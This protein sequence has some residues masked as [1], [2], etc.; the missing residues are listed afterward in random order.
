MIRRYLCWQLGDSVLL[1]S[2]ALETRCSLA[3]RYKHIH[4]YRHVKVLLRVT[5]LSVIL[6]K[7]LG[8][9]KISLFNFI[10]KFVRYVSASLVINITF[11]LCYVERF[12]SRMRNLPFFSY[13]QNVLFQFVV[14]KA[15]KRL[16]SSFYATNDVINYTQDHDDLL[17]SQKCLTIPQIKSSYSRYIMLNRG[18]RI[19][20]LMA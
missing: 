3:L 12:M 16:V 15:L 2:N 9:S 11:L 20:A 5:Y 17:D 6:L 18:S 4:G 19:N 14:R 10:V 8:K 7:S 1:T 13:C